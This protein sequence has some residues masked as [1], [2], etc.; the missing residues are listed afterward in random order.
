MTFRFA[1]NLSLLFPEL[2]F[3]DRFAAAAETG[4]DAVEILFPYES[5]ASAI[6]ERLDESGLPLV[7]MNAPPPNASG[8]PRGFAAAPGGEERFDRDLR[9]ALDRAERLGA[10]TIHVM[11]GPGEG[12]EARAAFV[13][14]LRRAT[15]EAPEQRFA[16]EPLNRIDN[17]GYFLSDFDL[18]LEV[19]DEVNAPNLGLQF[20]AYHAQIIVGDALAAWNRYGSRAVHVQI[21]DAPGRVEPGRGEIDFPGFF[22]RLR[23]SGYDGHVG[24]EYNPESGRERGLDW[25]REARGA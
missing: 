2:P 12:P 4:F 5:D 6:A 9:R 23:A 14:N 8:G 7:L 11:S 22:A 17:P 10:R 19:I 1:A 21:G 18:A 13:G 3:L 15:E 24:A 25:M 20:D 16:I